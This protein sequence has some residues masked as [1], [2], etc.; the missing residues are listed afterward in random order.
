MH[1][2]YY[3]ISGAP[4]QNRIS[5]ATGFLKNGYGYLKMGVGFGAKIILSIYTPMT[6]AFS[7]L[8]RKKK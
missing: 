4:L 6:R 7:P 8:L 3:T 2:I 5:L 1:G